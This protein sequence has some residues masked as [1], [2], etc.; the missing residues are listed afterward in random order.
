MM[1]TQRARCL[2]LSVVCLLSCLFTENVFAASEISV[3]RG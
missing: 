1:S 3:V 2:V